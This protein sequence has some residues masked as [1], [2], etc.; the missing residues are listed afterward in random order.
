MQRV[1]V[2]D[3]PLLEGLADVEAVVDDL[4]GDDEPLGGEELGAVLELVDLELAPEPLVA[5]GAAVGAEAGGRVDAHVVPDVA[6]LVLVGPEVA[7][8]ARDH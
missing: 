5:L 6:Q 1:V 3:V 2:D 7:E 4:V 8:A